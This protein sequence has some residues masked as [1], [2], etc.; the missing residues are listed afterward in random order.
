MRRRIV[1]GDLDGVERA[2][3]DAVD[4]D[5]D[6]AV[7][8]E[9]RA[10]LAY[11]RGQ[12]S[13]A[14]THADRAIA[15]DASLVA[16]HL[17]RIKALS[18][19]GHHTIAA[20]KTDLLLS[21]ESCDNEVLSTAAKVYH[22]A[23]IYHSAAKT[24][25]LLAGRRQD[26]VLVRAR[27]IEALELSGDYRAAID[28]S[29]M[30]CK[31][32]TAPVDMREHCLLLTLRWGE[33]ADVTAAVHALADADLDKALESLTDLAI[34]SRFADAE[35]VVRRGAEAGAAIHPALAASLSRS[36]VSQAK[37]AEVRGDMLTALAAWG[38]IQAIGVD[39]R[40]APRLE[41]AGIAVSKSATALIAQDKADEADAQI[42]A[43]LR[44]WPTARAWSAKAAIAKAGEQWD[45][46][47]QAC[48][49]LAILGEGDERDD[50]VVRAIRAIRKS[51][52]FTASLITLTRM[53]AAIGPQ[54]DLDEAG[55]WAFEKLRRQV[56]DDLKAGDSAAADAGYHALIAWDAENAEL[57]AL[58]T[59]LVKTHAV[60]M[61][62]AR[63]AGDVPT[64][65]AAAH[66]LVA[67][68]PDRLDALKFLADHSLR[69]GL[70]ANAARLYERVLVLVP[71]DHRYFYKIGKAYRSTGNDERGMEVLRRFLEIEPEHKGARELLNEMSAR[72]DG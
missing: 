27:A 49:E 35:W 10:A 41:K 42:D 38:L 58:E 59:K 29:L 18:R 47:G 19:I 50:A 34:A 54:A 39:D 67:L 56:R 37:D 3:A 51:R 65:V 15:L 9:L 63:K 2:L 20:E 40:A 11:R 1:A 6:E 16:A 55:S 71:E 24:W 21:I 30:L 28:Q 4:D 33:Q 46:L 43:L 45:A 52:N 13:I 48:G 72:H 32:G 7:V 66:S 64:A 25:L 60:A 44:V 68:A 36:I 61:S 26:D 31:A 57:P 8:Q 17:V 53:A 14:L 12:T 23:K 69:V 5:V 22:K 62:D 70:H